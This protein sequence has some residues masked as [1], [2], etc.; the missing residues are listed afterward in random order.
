MVRDRLANPGN[1]SVVE[2]DLLVETARP[3]GRNLNASMI[4]LSRARGASPPSKLDAIACGDISG[5]VVHPIFIHIAHTVGCLFL[6]HHTDS[7]DEEYDTVSEL[8]AVYFRLALHALS[9]FEGHRLSLSPLDK[10]Q[11]YTIIATYLYLKHHF[12]HGWGMLSKA[13]EVLVKYGMH[14][15][16]PSNSEAMISASSM[17][18]GH[19]AHV[20]TS[21]G[22]GRRR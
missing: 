13:N 10:V 5:L 8:E 18:E 3:P 20:W 15:T 16:I 19:R 2:I 14:I 12:N 4:R 9:D 22:L 6:N 21:D 7:E 1:R 11:A 17:R